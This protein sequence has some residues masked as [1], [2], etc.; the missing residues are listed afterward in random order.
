MKRCES[1]WQK[2]GWDNPES[3]RHRPYPE[4]LKLFLLSRWIGRQNQRRA[5][6]REKH[7]HVRLRI[8]QQK[9]CGYVY[10]KEIT[11]GL[12]VH[13]DCI[14]V[15]AV[16]WLHYWEGNRQEGQGSP[17]GGNRLQVSDIFSLSLLS[18]RRKQTSVTSPTPFSRQIW[19]E[20]SLKILCCHNDT[21]FHLNLTFLKPWANQRVFLMEMFVLSY[22]NELCI[23]PRLCL[24]VY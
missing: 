6:R 2:H 20:V 11:C 9:W 19:K 10:V 16:L 21:W 14:M 3:L 13:H 17:N 24:Q 12:L 23:Y 22:V 4:R 7:E 1:S 8:K 5:W 18:G 15:S